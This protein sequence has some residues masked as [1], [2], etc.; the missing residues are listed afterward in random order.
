VH[1]TFLLFLRINRTVRPTATAD[2]T[3]EAIANA[4]I[5]SPKGGTA[6]VLVI[7]VVVVALVTLPACEAL[8]IMVETSSMHEQSLKG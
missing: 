8:A 1:Q 5:K 4:V 7:D 6:V 2:I 3:T